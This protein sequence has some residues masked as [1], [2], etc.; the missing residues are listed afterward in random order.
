MG[1]YDVQHTKVKW[2]GGGLS[3]EKDVAMSMLYVRR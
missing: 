3:S 1:Q 2:G